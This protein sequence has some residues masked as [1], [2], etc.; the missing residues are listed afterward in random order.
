M[1]KYESLLELIKSNAL[2]VVDFTLSS[3]AKSN[4]YLDLRKITM[5]PEGMEMIGELMFS[6]IRDHMIPD[7]IGG[8]TLGADPISYITAYYAYQVGVDMRPFSVRREGKKHGAGSQVEGP[9]NKGDKVCIIE[10]TIASGESALRA[11]IAVE[12][13]GGIILGV[14]AL[15]DRLEGGRDL[16]SMNGINLISL[17][18]IDQILERT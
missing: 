5:L 4:F 16:L 9:F 13:A 11:C 1:T 12:K 14:A 15:A 8:L 18:T 3:G 10:D 17:Y 7:S 2:S 6:K